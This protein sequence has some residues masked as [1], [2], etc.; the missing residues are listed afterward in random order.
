[1]D[2]FPSIS[3]HLVL[4]CLNTE[5]N[6]KGHNCNPNHVSSTMRRGTKVRVKGLVK[7]A[8]HNGKIGIVTKATAPGEG[9]RVGVKLQDGSGVL[10]VKIE[11]LEEIKSSPR[12]TAT[13]SK[14]KSASAS[15]PASTLPKERTLKRDNALLREV[16]GSPDPNVLALYYHFADRAF[17]CF[18]ASEYNVQM[19]RY[20]EKGL[21]VRLICPRMIGGNEYFLVGLQHAQHD[22]N[23]LCEV[24]FNCGRSFTGISMLVKKRCFV[25]HKPLPGN[26][27]CPSCLCACFC[28]DSSCIN[29]NSTIRSDHER[30][31]KK[32]DLTK[33]VVEKESL[34]LLQ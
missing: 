33:V 9:Q 13:V 26:S 24:A 32:I 30:L 27:Q 25:C 7:A 2:F 11:N 34:Q 29:R 18:N 31:C 28:T 6:R 1:M 15:T 8:K 21:S 22:K 5:Q 12:T 20:Y 16:D 3:L 19:L 17:D 10:A 23:S 4:I 14:P